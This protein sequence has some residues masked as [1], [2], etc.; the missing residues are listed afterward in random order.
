MPTILRM[1]D[2]MREYDRANRQPL[3]IDGEDPPFFSAAEDPDPITP[4]QTR[5]LAARL[6]LA[7]L[8]FRARL[9]KFGDQDPWRD[10]PDA[11]EDGP[12]GV[13]AYVRI[14]RRRSNAHQTWRRESLALLAAFANGWKS[15]L[16]Q[17]TENASDEEE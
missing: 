4:E 2:L 16:G 9:P 14:L 11:V 7:K 13:D 10:D 15:L 17:M 3:N 5:L 8:R 1:E 6:Q 12:G